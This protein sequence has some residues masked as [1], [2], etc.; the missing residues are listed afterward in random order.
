MS[1][2][3]DQED[4]RPVVT[5]GNP[6][7]H[8]QTVTGL[9]RRGLTSVEEN[10][11]DGRMYASQAAVCARQAVLSSTKTGESEIVAPAQATYYAMGN[12]IEELVVSALT[13]ERALLFAQY[14][15]PDVG[16]NMGG[17]VDGIV[18]VAGK[19]RVLEIKSCGELPSEP[20]LEHR[21]QAMVYSAI[22]GLPPTVFYFSRHVAS[23]DGTLKIREFALTPTRDDLRATMFRVCYAREAIEAGL[24]PE[25]PMEFTKE[26]QCGF[27]PWKPAC[28]HSE[29]LPRPVVDADQH[30]ALVKAANARVKELMS[31]D[32]I[33]RR[34]RGVLVHV[35][36]H[37][38][39][40]AKRLLAGDWSTLT[41][42]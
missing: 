6:F 19:I 14:K 9:V 20:K 42:D 7:S 16:L 31:P 8:A 4:D 11:R 30:V 13:R 22:T 36:K 41:E 21:A 27:C 34:R 40:D 29:A 12:A 25:M 33:T 39:A 2:D 10:D 38:T 32:A 23:F 37:G 26:S 24:I 15:L 35:Q 28:W 5:R 1:L 3:F 18:S 17:Y